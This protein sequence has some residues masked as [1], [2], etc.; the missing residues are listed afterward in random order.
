M[1][2]RE[3]RIEIRIDEQGRITAEAHGFTGDV[4]I[5]EM[6]KLLA[7]A[8]PGCIKLDRK[9]PDLRGSIRAEGSQKIRPGS[10]P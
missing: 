2:E 7:D 10:Q 4:C 6:E 8:S 3:H 1:A 9:Q 5:R